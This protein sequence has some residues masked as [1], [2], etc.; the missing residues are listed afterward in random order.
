MRQKD[1]KRSAGNIY[2]QPGDAIRGEKV[3]VQARKI[4][5]MTVSAGTSTHQIQT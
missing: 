2:S 3:T 1:L 4:H 5:R